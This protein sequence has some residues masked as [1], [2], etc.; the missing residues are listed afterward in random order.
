MPQGGGFLNRIPEDWAKNC[1]SGG[2]RRGPAA[3]HP[4]MAPQDETAKPV[5]P[6][7]Q[8]PSTRASDPRQVRSERPDA[9]T[10]SVQT[11]DGGKGPPA[12]GRRG[13]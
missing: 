13:A 6:T 7:R 3:V 8:V 4:P 12:G 9:R 10:Q 2:H 5:Q 11:P 1:P